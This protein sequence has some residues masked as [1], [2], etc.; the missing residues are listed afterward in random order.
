MF[1]CRVWY[2]AG[3][4]EK[5]VYELWLEGRVVAT[6]FG[7]EDSARGMLE[8]YPAGAV[9]VEVVETRTEL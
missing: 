9:V 1:G 7:S 4:D 8:Y 5:Y 2:T 6:G 3:M